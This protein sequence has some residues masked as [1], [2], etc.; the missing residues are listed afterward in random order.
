[1]VLASIDPA[2]V[3]GLVDNA[4]SFTEGLAAQREP[5][6]T[7]VARA[8]EIAGDAA[9]ISAALSE[10]TPEIS[11]TID[12]VR[13]AAA[14]GRAAISEARAVV[15]EAAP[16][17]RQLA[18]AAAVVTPARV[19]DL[20][21]Q[22]QLVAGG[23]AQQGPNINAILTDARASAEAV[24]TIATELAARAP[25][26]GTIVDDAAS[27][28]GNVRTAAESLPELVAAAEPGVRRASE[29][30]EAL[31]PEA[32]SAI[33][34]DV[35]AFIASLAEQREAI[36]GLI[37]NASGAAARIDAV[38]SA[39]AQRT[40]QIGAVIDSVEETARSAQT[41]AARLP[42]L[43]DTI[44]PGL[45][46]VS[47]ALSAIDPDA[48]Q[49]IVESA[50]QF[51]GVLS[52]ESGRI[53]TIL[54]DAERAAASAGN[55]LQ[56][57][58]ERR[59]QIGTAIDQASA[60]VTDARRF[61]GSL[62]EFADTLTPGID[63]LAAVLTAIDEAAIRAVVDDVEEFTRALS[64][65]APRIGRIA[66]SIETTSADAAAIA[67][68]LRGELD[69]IS[70]AITD[71]QVALA[72]A[73]RF[74][75]EL[76]ALLEVIEP[77]VI[78]AG[79]VLE[80]ID[81]AAVG[82]IVENVRSVSQTLADARGEIDS[83]LAVTGQAAR[84]VERVTS[85]VAARTEE[86]QAAIDDAAR[87]AASLGAIGPQVEQIAGQAGNVLDNIGQTVSAVNTQAVNSIIENVETAA[88]AIGSRAGEI[89]TAI[90]NAVNAARGLSEGLGTLGGDDGTIKQVLD[91]ARRIGANLEAASS[92]VSLVVDRAGN[93]LDGPTQ[94]LI[95]N[96]SDAAADVSDVAGAFATRA[97]SIAGGLS[98]FSQ[99]GLDDLRA[100]L[101]QG[102][103]TLAAIEAAVSS[104]ERN[105]S[106]VIFGGADGP[107]YTPQ[108]R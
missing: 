13:A 63:N 30:L 102:R 86:I 100:L 35:A 8:N 73:R 84:Q 22:A 34:R 24:R 37:T 57:L 42:G 53:A 20:L 106:R 82:E 6:E 87:F 68:R 32:V 27:A 39:I 51:A 108:R 2:S 33:Q 67:T 93:I 95:A 58:D 74:A 65:E 46:S 80:A 105:P 76:P 66:A 77:G 4:A 17:V 12:D 89:G 9:E 1:D 90:D 15:T 101:N 59:P 10:K 38:A 75:Q 98:K 55:V 43:A 56:T 85:G 19:D 97:D 71:A 83:V 41:F 70:V 61:A 29:A 14:D 94:R 92:R 60:A 40:P 104:F 47:D 45:Q 78:N 91:Q 21:T 79:V 26:I 7:L 31:D 107:R 62:P 64:A 96:V 3:E 50:S 69:A 88:A 48:V 81:P 72:E 23:L 36:A 25:E 18:A 44:E 49:S 5:L 52:A 54:A 16:A 11:A 103:G 28:A 99:S